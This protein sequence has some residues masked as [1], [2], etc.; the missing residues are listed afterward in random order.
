MA[1]VATLGIA[2]D[3]RAVVQGTA[4]LDTFSA[5]AGKASDATQDLNATAGKSDTVI[6]AMAAAAARLNIPLNDYAAKMA[7]AVKATNDNVAASGNLAGT[8]ARSL[9]SYHGHSRRRKLQPKPLE[10]ALCPRVAKVDHN[11]G[12][13]ASPPTSLRAP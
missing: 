13:R 6:R 9:L 2:I 3:S 1:D 5:S 8:L 11:Q 7:G 10:S 4:A 12:E